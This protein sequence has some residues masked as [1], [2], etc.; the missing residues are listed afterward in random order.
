VII[1]ETKE[2]SRSNKAHEICGGKKIR[3]RGR[4]TKSRE[5]MR[6]P[7][8]PAVAEWEKKRSSKKKKKEMFHHPKKKRL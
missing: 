3:S 2:V 6:S 1:M 7:N 8:A 5:R 4:R